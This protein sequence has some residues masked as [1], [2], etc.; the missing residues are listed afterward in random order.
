MNVDGT[1]TD[2]SVTLLSQPTA[3][4]SKSRRLM[5]TMGR[6][7]PWPTPQVCAPV[8][9]RAAR[10]SPSPHPQDEYGIYPYETAGEND[11]VRKRS[12]EGR[13]LQIRLSLV[14]VMIFHIFR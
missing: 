10:V 6:V 1:M 11:G 14:S 9:S 3:V 2:G 13:A 12:F 5:H 8:A 4:R 7:L